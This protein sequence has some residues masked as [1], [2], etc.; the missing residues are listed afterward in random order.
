MN[1]AGVIKKL[2]LV[3][4]DFNVVLMPQ[5]KDKEAGMPIL[6]YETIDFA[7]TVQHCDLVDL[8]LIGCRLTWTNDSVST[9]LDRALAN[10]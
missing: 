10:K 4:G 8:H 9:K 1:I 2:W 3:L 6:H 7:M 5:D